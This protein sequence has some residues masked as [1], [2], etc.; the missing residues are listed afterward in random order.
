V[1]PYFTINHLIVY[2]QYSLTITLIES[3]LNFD[4]IAWKG[5]SIK[6]ALD[7]IV[8]KRK[9]KEK[10]KEKKRKRKRKQQEAQSSF[11]LL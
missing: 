8:Y 9:K 10:K 7:S 2:I 4:F 11:S 5:V 1:L 3:L 6:V